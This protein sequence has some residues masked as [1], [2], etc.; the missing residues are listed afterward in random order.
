MSM[1]KL[2]TRTLLVM[3]LGADHLMNGLKTM[4]M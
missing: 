1:K 4:R 3:Y 2:P